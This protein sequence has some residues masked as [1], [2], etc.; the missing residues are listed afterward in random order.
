M[1]RAIS[2]YSTRT[3]TPDGLKR[4]M[5]HLNA[6]TDEYGWVLERNG[7]KVLVEITTKDLPQMPEDLIRPVAELLKAWPK[8]SV[9][10]MY[11]DSAPDEFEA[12]MARAVA[13]ALAEM[14]PIVLDDH[15]GRPEIIHAPGQRPTSG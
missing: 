2:A 9:V 4:V 7:R 6:G 11:D 5:E 12:R 14:W 15:T 1:A 13:V 8:S 10:L 3:I